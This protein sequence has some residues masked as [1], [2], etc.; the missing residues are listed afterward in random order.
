ML[1]ITTFIY[2]KELLRFAIVMNGK[3]KKWIKTV[4]LGNKTAQK[5][6]KESIKSAI[7]RI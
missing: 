5:Q 1:K 6:L 2:K 4:H 7:K 3:K